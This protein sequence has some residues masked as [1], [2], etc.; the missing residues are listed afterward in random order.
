MAFRILMSASDDWN[1][2]WND[3]KKEFDEKWNERKSEFDQ[4]WDDTMEDADRAAKISFGIIAAIVIGSIIFVI[5]SVIICIYCV[6]KRRQ[7]SSGTVVQRGAPPTQQVTTY[8]FPYVAPQQSGMVAPPPNQPPPQGY[9]PGYPPAMAPAP[10]PGP[11]Q[12]YPPM[13]A[14]GWTQPNPGVMASAPPPYSPQPP[15]MG[16]SEKQM[17]SAPPME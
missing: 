13:A 5:A 4:N 7:F 15:P 16:F 11:A 3:K 2:D 6:C 10:V 12:P 1:K 17:A 8:S 14:G 9:G